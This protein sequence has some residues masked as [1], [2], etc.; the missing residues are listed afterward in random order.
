MNGKMTPEIKEKLEKLLTEALALAKE[1]Q[2]GYT[3]TQPIANA[4]RA[5]RG[6]KHLY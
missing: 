5:V 6:E 4:L 3:A 1:A 2:L